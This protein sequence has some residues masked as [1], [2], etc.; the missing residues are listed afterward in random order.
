MTDDW[1][2]WPQ[3]MSQI[4]R[5]IHRPLHPDVD[6]SDDRL[7]LLGAE[8]GGEVGAGVGGGGQI[9]VLAFL[10]GDGPGPEDHGHDLGEGRV[11]LVVGCREQGL[12][13]DV[14][15]VVGQDQLAELLG[16]DPGEVLHHPQRGGPDLG[17]HDQRL[18]QGVDLDGDDGDLRAS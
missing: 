14:A 18:V 15:L 9:A 17:P 1:Q 6:R 16:F 7:D 13:D 5:M 3:K 10:E 4:A 11:D 2:W 12:T 8:L